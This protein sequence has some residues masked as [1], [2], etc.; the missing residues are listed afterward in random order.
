MKS[1]FFYALKLFMFLICCICLSI[2]WPFIL[3]LCKNGTANR[4][5]ARSVH[6]LFKN[7]FCINIKYIDIEK[8]DENK[9]YIYVCNHQSFLD[10][11]IFGLIFP[12]NAYIIS[13][14]SLKY[15]PY[16]GFLYYLSGN[17]YIKRG[18]SEKAKETL[19]KVIGVLKER[20]S[21]LFIF[22]QG[23]R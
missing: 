13:K 6:Y 14:D 23:T 10:A 15:V 12:R 4:A 11:V 20:K 2:M 19:N 17:F 7:A 21:S 16:F 22:P 3:L 18:H 1:Y 5:Y 8:I 9:N